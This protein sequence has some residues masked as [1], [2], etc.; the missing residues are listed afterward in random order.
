ME[1][2]SEKRKC[3]SLSKL[4]GLF[5]L[6]PALFFSCERDV[7]INLGETFDPGTE[8]SIDVVA[9]LGKFVEGQNGGSPV[10]VIE[11]FAQDA[12]QPKITA[13]PS[14]VKEKGKSLVT[15]SD[16]PGNLVIDG[17]NTKASASGSV[18]ALQKK[19][20]TQYQLT[21]GRGPNTVV[22]VFIN[23]SDILRLPSAYDNTLLTADIAKGEFT[24]SP[25]ATTYSGSDTPSDVGVGTSRNNFWKGSVSYSGYNDAASPKF[26]FTPFPN[27]TEADAVWEQVGGG[28]LQYEDKEFFRVK[29]TVI[30]QVKV[31]FENISDI[32]I[33]YQN[34]PVYGTGKTVR[35]MYDL[36]TTKDFYFEFERRAAVVDARLE[37]VI[38]MPSTPVV[39]NFNDEAVP[40]N[41]VPVKTLPVFD[42]PSGTLNLEVHAA[43]LDPN[44]TLIIDNNSGSNQNF[45]PNVASNTIDIAS[46]ANTVTFVIRVRSESGAEARYTFV[47][48]L[49]AP[50]YATNAT[51]GSTYF[52]E[53]FDPSKPAGSAPEKIYEVH[54]FYISSR[55]SIA[56]GDQLSASLVFADSSKKPVKA[57]V[58]VVGGGGGGGST[59]QSGGGGA[60]GVIH[61]KDYTLPEGLN[62][63]V[64]VGNGG[65]AELTGDSSHVNGYGSTPTGTAVTGQNGGNSV[66]G[67]GSNRLEA[68]GGG[69]GAN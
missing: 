55:D 62:F 59:Y 47:G 29:A 65:K 33:D 24:E 60:G 56:L 41:L 57:E 12:P 2:K 37:S 20:E 31:L 5:F 17:G 30:P 39:F 48:M 15:I 8:Y 43:T 58:L 18:P 25:L 28:L 6:I 14:K 3:G 34:L 9:K 51:G 69:G 45:V 7:E 10:F 50:K 11:D 22:V 27:N 49:S 36:A 16:I 23:P 40:S 44:A 54:Y 19:S 68:P 52:L 35:E 67:T 61:Y 66:F 26:D 13:N 21:A 1:K 53:E 4:L 63:S 42:V 46:G 32:Y 38:I 64:K